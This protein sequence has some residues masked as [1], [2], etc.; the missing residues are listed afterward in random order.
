MGKKDELWMETK[1]Q[2]NIIEEIEEVIELT[3]LL[4]LEELKAIGISEEELK[5]PTEETLNKIQEYFKNL[6]TQK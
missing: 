4:S 3:N 6:V 5:N 2:E 1:E